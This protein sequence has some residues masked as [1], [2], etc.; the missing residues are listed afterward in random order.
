MNKD[1][2]YATMCNFKSSHSF[3]TLHDNW[4]KCFSFILKAFK[5]G[6]TDKT[7]KSLFYDFNM[8]NWSALNLKNTE[9]AGMS[10]NEIIDKFC[11]EAN[12]ISDRTSYDRL[13][14]THYLFRNAF[15]DEINRI[16]YPTLYEK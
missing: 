5:V 3:T 4:Y 16:K 11:G 14:R 6:Y 12:Y 13:F 1:Q 2:Y 8:D 10:Q 15:P 9:Y 7:I